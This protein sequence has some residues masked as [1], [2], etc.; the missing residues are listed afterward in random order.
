MVCFS[1]DE[2]SGDGQGMDWRIMVG[3]LG[4]CGIMSR[5]GDNM[6][7]SIF[8]F[9]VLAF[10]VRLLCRIPPCVDTQHIFLFCS[11]PGRGLT[12][13]RQSGDCFMADVA[14]LGTCETSKSDEERGGDIV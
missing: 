3:W 11:G 9:H 14:N 2:W 13:D 4:L 10:V 5:R 7:R 8:T 6:S 1:G 12:P